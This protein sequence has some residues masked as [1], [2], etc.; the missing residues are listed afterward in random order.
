MRW[1]LASV[2]FHPVRLLRWPVE[3]H[4]FKCVEVLRASYQILVSVAED[5]CL[6]LTIIQEVPVT[7]LAVICIQTVARNSDITRGALL[8]DEYVLHPIRKNSIETWT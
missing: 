2:S 5:L 7:R 3:V 6:A 8:P 1:N 4:D